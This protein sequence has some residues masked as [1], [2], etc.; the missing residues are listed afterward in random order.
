MK[1]FHQALPDQKIPLNES[2][3]M[4]KQADAASSGPLR[5]YN[6]GKKGHKAS[7]CSEP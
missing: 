4:L 1:N 3:A 2:V 6:C 7:Q 5:F